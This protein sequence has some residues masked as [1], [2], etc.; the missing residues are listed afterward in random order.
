M[1]RRQI[2]KQSALGGAMML[3]GG[4]QAQTSRGPAV[5][6]EQLLQNMLQ[7]YQLTQ[8]IHVAA[9]LRIADLLKDGPMTVSQL[10]AATKTHEDSLYRLLRALAGMGVFF[11]EHG[12]RFRLTPTAALLRTGVPGSVRVRAVAAG[13]EWT[14]RP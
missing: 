13:E 5:A 7:G 2:L 6:P 9:K 8:M 1:N 14:W 4:A 12:P 10:A 3:T 11:E